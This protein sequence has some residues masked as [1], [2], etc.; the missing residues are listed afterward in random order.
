M[1]AKTRGKTWQNSPP[2]H[3]STSPPAR[4][5]ASHKGSADGTKSSAVAAST[6]S[7]AHTSAT[8][9]RRV[10][11]QISKRVPVH[12]QTLCPP[13]CVCPR[14]AAIRFG[15]RRSSGGR[16]RASPDGGHRESPGSVR[17]FLYGCK[18]APRGR[19]R[20]RLGG[21]VVALA[22]APAPFGQTTPVGWREQILIGAA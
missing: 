13:C 21:L 11:W 7:T 16:V 1:N 8:I 12:G 19:S 2:P 18:A 15:W 22:A 17:N 10:G 9:S 5:I 6:S 3:E 4:S 14:L 20:R